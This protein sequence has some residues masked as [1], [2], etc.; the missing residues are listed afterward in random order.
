MSKGGFV[1][2]FEGVTKNQK[3]LMGVAAATK[4]FVDRGYI[5]CWPPPDTQCDWD[6]I[7][8]KLFETPLKVQVKTTGNK[9]SSG[10]YAVGL[11]DGGYVDDVCV[12]VPKDYDL[13]F[14]LDAEGNECVWTK[15]ELKEHKHSVHMKTS[16]ARIEGLL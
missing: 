1:G 15:D 16:L 9:V 3:T 14:G 7:I 13:L 5:V 4:Y 10:A 6:F 12:K 2:I 8:T 11:K